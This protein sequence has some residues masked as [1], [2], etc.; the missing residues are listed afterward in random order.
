[1]K[2]LEYYM[3][4]PYKM[5]ITPDPDEGGYV[6]SFPDLPGCLTYADTLEE[7]LLM[8]EDAKRTWLEAALE[9]N[10][11]VKEPASLD[12]YSGQFKLRLPRELHKSLAEH[13][14]EAGISMNQY[15]LYLLAMNDTK[16]D[17]TIVSRMEAARAST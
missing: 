16:L 8:A 12:D 15:C 14:R 9:D 13:A 6:A 2:N 10:I 1:M 7:L 11:L 5:E 4:L 3:A 17:T